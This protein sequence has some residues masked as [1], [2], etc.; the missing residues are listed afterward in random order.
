M[1][2]LYFQSPLLNLKLQLQDGAIVEA[3]FVA[4]VDKASAETGQLQG[5]TLEQLQQYVLSGQQRFDLP[6][7]PLG[8]EFQQ[9]VWQALQKI[10]AGEVRSYGELAYQLGSSA[11]AVGN[12]CRKNPIPLLIPCHRVVAKTGLGGF[13]GQTE[14]ALLELKQRLLRHEGVEIH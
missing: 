7:K 12:A 1:S 10:P 2:E 5:R 8:T 14:G 11:R 13:A 3:D 4:T 9:R 6:L